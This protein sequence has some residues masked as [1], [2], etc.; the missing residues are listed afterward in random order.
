MCRRSGMVIASFDVLR[1]AVGCPT[2]RAAFWLPFVNE[3]AHRF[4]ITSAGRMAHFL[5]QVAHE[6]ARFRRIEENLNY[7]VE[8]LL[9]RFS[10]RRISEADARKYGRNA[11]HP[12]D[13]PAIANLIYGGRW[14]LENLGNAESGDGWDFRGMG[15]IQLTGRRLR[16][17]CGRA[18]GVDLLSRPPKLLEAEYAALSA[19]WFWDSRGLNDLADIDDLETLVRRING[20]LNG[21]DDRRAA[22][23]RARLALRAPGT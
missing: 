21:L 4:G 2:S 1:R 16:V 9:A 6:S 18:L 17:D 20:G 8:A 15:L 23:E 10:R 11:G 14:G 3:A 13:Q 22:L 7:T 19:G 12:A 5:A